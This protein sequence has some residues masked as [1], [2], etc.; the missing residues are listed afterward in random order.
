ALSTPLVGWLSD[1]SDRLKLLA[2]M[3]VAASCVAVVIT[4]MGPSS[5]AYASMMM[6]FFMVTMS[7]RFSPAMT[8]VTNAVEA[9]Y[10]GGF[11]SVSTALQQGASAG[12]TW[13]AGEFVTKGPDGRLI[14][15]PTLGYAAVGFFMFT[16]YL[17]AQLRAA[18]PHVAI[19]AP[20]PPVAPSEAPA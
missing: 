6:A 10:R 5:F 15:I 4:H 1:H 9:R 19:P 20:K 17:A 14:G 18:A 11:M 3:S 2:I 13:L 8:M 16:V 7:G 12:A